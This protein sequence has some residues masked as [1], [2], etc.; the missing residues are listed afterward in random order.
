MIGPLSSLLTTP[1]RV[2]PWA[3]GVSVQRVD[4][5][6]A[7]QLDKKVGPRPWYY[8]RQPA[9]SQAKVSGQQPWDQTM[10]V[11]YS[12]TRSDFPHLRPIQQPPQEP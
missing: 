1:T 5:R 6:I 8:D 4:H 12:R 11:P 3:V 7:L 9:D 10:Y 2:P